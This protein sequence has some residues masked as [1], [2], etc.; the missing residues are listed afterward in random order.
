VRSRSI[1][2]LL[3]MAG[4]VGCWLEVMRTNRCHVVAK[5]HVA[6]SSCEKHAAERYWVYAAIDLVHVRAQNY[7]VK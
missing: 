4:A 2:S 6:Y 5:R 7:K 3:E 1:G